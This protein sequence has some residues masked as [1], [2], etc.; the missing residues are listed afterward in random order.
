VRPLL[1]RALACVLH[2]AR[3]RALTGPLATPTSRSAP[4]VAEGPGV[5]HVRHGRGVHFVDDRRGARRT[6]RRQRR[7]VSQAIRHA[8]QCSSLRPS[9]A[10]AGTRPTSCASATPNMC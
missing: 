10:A 8:R 4:A 9:I 2:P 7:A 5:E 1:R 3:L 6:R